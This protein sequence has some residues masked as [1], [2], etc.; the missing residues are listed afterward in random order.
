MTRIFNIIVFIIT[1]VAYLSTKISP[2]NFW[3]AGFAALSI[4]VLLVLNALLLLFYL[5]R[6]NIWFLFPLVALLLG[7]KYL[8]VSFSVN[9]NGNPGAESFA[10]L[11]YNV[12]IFNASPYLQNKSSNTGKSMVEWVVDNN[13][14]IK[15]LQEYFNQD[16]SDVYNTFSKISQDKKY[17]AHIQP[18]FIDQSGA[19]FGLAIFSKFPIVAKGEVL[20][21]KDRQ[22][23]AI[24]ADL[25]VGDDTLRVYNVHLQ[26][27][28]IDENKI[29]EFE[30]AKENYTDI[31]R[32]LRYGFVSRA[33]QVDNLISHI[34][35]CPYRL[36]V[37]GDFNDIP[38]SYTYFS[39][40][41]H[42][43]NAFEEAGL[44]LGFSYNGKL[45]FLRIDNQFYSN[46]LEAQS[47]KT[48]REVPYSDHYPVRASYTIKK[49][50]TS[51]SE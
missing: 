51:V 8:L 9:F 25:L 27:M 33:K 2:E 50:D 41:E 49:E 30:K 22:Q 7:Y 23:H 1:I 31:A 5:F 13:A 38:Y 34:N 26:S 19:Q 29:S 11:S 18:F 36:I 35:E 47:F 44:G 10:V 46:G 6:R 39:L 12:R 20:L 21:K 32:K 3:I 16:K 4:P 42:L 43:H 17:Q 48:H 24:Y 45:F 37:C 14:D 28:S 40:K 15:C